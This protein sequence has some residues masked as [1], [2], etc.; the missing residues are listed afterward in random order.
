MSGC[1]RPVRTTP[2]Q[3]P[4]LFNAHL[5]QD[6]LERALHP[7]RAT[8]PGMTH[9]SQ[10]PRPTAETWE[11]IRLEF[12]SGVS[13]PVLAERHGVTER[14]IRR[15]AA[16]EGWRRSDFVPLGLAP[17]PPWMRGTP[18]REEAIEADPALEEVGEAEATARFG[19]LFNPDPKTLR[20]YAFRR[21]SESAAVDRP[22][23]AMVWMRLAQLTD[24][25]AHR[26]EWDGQPF[27]DLDYIRAAYL[28]SV[29]DAFPDDRADPD[30]P[31]N[32]APDLG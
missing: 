8:L 19:L 16:L 1:R 18:S 6:R 7:T 32:E 25:C 29:H 2:A 21:A 27:R 20:S 4:R 24:R 30:A 14:S 11:Q 10:T 26:I 9:A 5:R 3:N 28:Q 23:E 17:P 12:V 15:R 31:A 13:A 22:Q